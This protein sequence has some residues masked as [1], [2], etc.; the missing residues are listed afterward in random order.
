MHN[1]LGFKV[2]SGRITELLM[3]SGCQMLEHGCVSISYHFCFLTILPLS[4][5]AFD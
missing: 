4:K 3:S 5:G 2:N 1:L